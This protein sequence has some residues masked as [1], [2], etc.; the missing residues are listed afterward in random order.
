[1]RPS[2]VLGAAV[3]VLVAVAFAQADG[4]D[5]TGKQE[6]IYRCSVWCLHRQ[7]VLFQSTVLFGQ[8]RPRQLARQTVLS[9]CFNLPRT[10]QLPSSR[11]TR[12]Q[13]HSS[14]TT[15][16][17]R[18]SALIMACVHGSTVIVH[19]SFPVDPLCP[20]SLQEPRQARHRQA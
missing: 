13:V 3:F 14:R 17:W 20:H 19:F 8:Q 2:L 1:M 15:V 6:C 12:S 4:A 5:A 16:Y 9:A 18:T 7:L 10:T 11:L